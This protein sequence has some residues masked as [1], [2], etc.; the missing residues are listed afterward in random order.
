MKANEV[1]ECLLRAGV[2][3]LY[4][5]NTVVTA[6]SFL[7]CGG[8]LS[9][10]T[11]E[12][13]RLPQTRQGSDEMD[14]LLGVYNDIFFDSV[15]IHERAHKINDYGAVLFVYSID[16]LDSL[17]NY[18]IGVTHDNPI[19]WDPDMSE[20]ERYFQRKEEFIYFQKGNFAQHITV[21]NISVPLPFDYLYEIVIDNPGEDR[22]EYLNEAL[23]CIAQTLYDCDLSLSVRVRQC[24]DHCSCIQKYQNSKPGYTYYRF[25][26][27]L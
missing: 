9:R 11:A 27:S 21:R 13:L 5:C 6:L 7:R 1:K 22:R 14:K 23:R 19:R 18:D 4:H 12:R 25:Q 15:D 17:S 10:Q 26:T 24:P 8:L 20:S 3:C 16:V 2:N